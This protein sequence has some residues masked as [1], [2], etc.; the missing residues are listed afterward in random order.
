MVADHNSM[1]TAPSVLKPRSVQKKAGLAL[2]MDRVLEEC[3][4]AAFDFSADPVHD[5]RVALRR[6]RSLADGLMAMD[7]DPAWKQMKRAGKRLFSQLGELR[8]A[9]VMEEW[10]RRLGGPD[11]PVTTSLLQFLAGREAQLKLD[12]AQALQDFD[13]KQWRRWSLSLPRR[14]NRV[15][16]G[17]ALFKHLALERWAEAYALHHSAMRNRSQ[18]AF[19]RLRIGIKRFR[20][21]VEN[22]LP[23]QHV[24]WSADLKEL[25]DLLGEVHDLDVLWTT[26]SQIAAF[27]DIEAR[28]RWRDKIVEERAGRIGQY[29]DKM[30]GSASLWH[31]WRADL[32]QGKQVEASAMNRL[33]LWASFL[34]PDFKHSL[35]VAR[36]SLQLYDQMPP[37]H[38]VAYSDAQRSIL[39]AAAFLHDVGRSKAQN[40][41]HKASYD[42]IRRLKPPLSWTEEEMRLVGVVA[43]YHRGA[44][45]RT[46]QATLTGLTPDQRKSTLYLASILRL[47]NAFDSDGDSR[48]GR[49]EVSEQNGFLAISA[50]GYSSQDRM[51]E[52]VAAARHLLEIVCRCPV[53]VKPLRNQNHK[54]RTRN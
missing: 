15:R 25:Q 39:Q 40:A 48:I 44:L 27:P 51:A 20:Y 41:H 32:P 18:L 50:Q 22:F 26:L 3:D 10:V 28:S 5:L 23:E 53:L 21:I 35:Q 47:A 16:A 14:T 33:K 11:D 34:D 13:R 42:L 49:L 2:W 17:S 7:P 54:P 46:G 6:C 9:Q 37:K 1:T 4:R 19:H 43:R 24:A 30:L 36:L 8:D 45:P 12:A 38:R 31:V 52:A 29:R